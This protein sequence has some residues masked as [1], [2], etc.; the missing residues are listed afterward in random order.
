MWPVAYQLSSQ[1]RFSCRT[2]LSSTSGFWARARRTI[3]SWLRMKSGTDAFEGFLTY[4]LW[5]NQSFLSLFENVLYS[6]Q[7]TLISIPFC[8]VVS[9]WLSE[10]KFLAGK[11]QCVHLCVYPLANPQASFLFSKWYIC[12]QICPV[13][14][15]FLPFFSF[16]GPPAHESLYN[17]LYFFIFIFLSAAALPVL[18]YADWTCCLRCWQNPDQLQFTSKQWM[19]SRA[20]SPLLFSSHLPSLN[21][22]FLPLILS[23]RLCFSTNSPHHFIVLF[24]WWVSLKTSKIQG[25]PPPQTVNLTEGFSPSTVTLGAEPPW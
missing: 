19:E 5:V 3:R 10:P 9:P 21:P 22:W 12:C 1:V 16:A 6:R 17:R 18:A 13:V 25:A 15:F 7:T 14:L 24:G 4:S 11:L 2:S 23:F 20:D 8:I